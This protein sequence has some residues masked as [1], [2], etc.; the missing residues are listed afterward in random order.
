VDGI[1]RQV[2]P[3]MHFFVE[4]DRTPFHDNRSTQPVLIHICR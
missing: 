3:G 2:A 1:G 4:G